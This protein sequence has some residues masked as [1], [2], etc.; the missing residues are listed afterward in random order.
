[1]R[2]LLPSS[3]QELRLTDCL[4]TNHISSKYQRAR[5][6]SP[7]LTLWI[8]HDDADG[9]L[10]PSSY[11][12]DLTGDVSQPCIVRVDLDMSRG[13]ENNNDSMLRGSDVGEIGERKG[14]VSTSLLSANYPED[15]SFP[16]TSSFPRYAQA[17][18]TTLLGV[19]ISGGEASESN[20]QE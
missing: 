19:Y 8:L 11:M 20:G 12:H 3:Q 4:V 16:I 10:D 18:D 13:F 7:T 5:F 15:F 1:M 14:R 9:C 2:Q 17:T 6:T